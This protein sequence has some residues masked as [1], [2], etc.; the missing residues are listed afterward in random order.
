RGRSDRGPR[1]RWRRRGPRRGR[2]RGHRGGRGGGHPPPQAALTP[3]ADAH[4]SGADP[5]MAGLVARFGPV[6]QD[7]SG[8]RPDLYAAL[9]RAITGQQLSVKAARAIHGRLLARFGDRPPTPAELL[10]DDPEEMRTAARLSRA[11]V[12]SMR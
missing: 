2:R 1:A 4:L 11:K 12:V 7:G 9:L 10:A 8:P 3:D 6:E 5:V